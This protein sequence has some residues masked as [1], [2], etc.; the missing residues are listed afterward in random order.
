MAALTSLAEARTIA[1]QIMASDE[2]MVGVHLMMS[3]GEVVVDREGVVR[4]AED[5]A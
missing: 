5:V 1:A 4:L 3:F 2:R